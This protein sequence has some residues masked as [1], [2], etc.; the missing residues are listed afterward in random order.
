MSEKKIEYKALYEIWVKISRENREELVQALN[1]IDSQSAEITEL[2][3]LNDMWQQK[4]IAMQSY[5]G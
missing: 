4:C 2:K 3:L 1:T 5:R